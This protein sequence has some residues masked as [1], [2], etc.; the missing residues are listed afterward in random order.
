MQAMA[1]HDSHAIKPEQGNHRDHP[2][3]GNSFEEEEKTVTMVTH[4]LAVLVGI[5]G[6]LIVER[7]LSIGSRFRNRRTA[8]AKNKVKDDFLVIIVLIIHFV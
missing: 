4:G 1:P 2:D 5:F 3:D 7:L 8:R 6:F